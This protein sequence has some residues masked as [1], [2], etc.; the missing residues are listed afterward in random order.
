MAPFKYIIRV[1]VGIEV[2]VNHIRFSILTAL[3]TPYLLQTIIKN[4]INVTNCSVITRKGL[5]FAVAS[6]FKRHL[7]S[8]LF[9]QAYSVSTIA[10]TVANPTIVCITD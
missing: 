8:E 1:S 9:F 7:K 10:S 6:T 5:S 2:Q 3:S 4:E